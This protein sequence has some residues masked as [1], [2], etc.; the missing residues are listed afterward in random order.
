MAVKLFRCPSINT[1]KIMPSATG[2]GSIP[3]PMP[4]KVK[5]VPGECDDW[6]CPLLLRNLR[7]IDFPRPK[8]SSEIERS[9][10]H[11]EDEDPNQN[12]KTSHYCAKYLNG[13]RIKRL[14]DC[15]RRCN[16]CRVWE[17]ERVPVIVS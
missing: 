2:L 17:N 4:S 6:H 3:I 14:S 11:G 10:H 7:A 15:L 16:Q 13:I 12:N 9:N 5:M 1:C 8:K